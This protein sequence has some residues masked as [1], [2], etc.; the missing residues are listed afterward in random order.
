MPD[1]KFISILAAPFIAAVLIAVGAS[2]VV[3]F[4]T[5][6]PPKEAEIM[7]FSY[8]SVR[9]AR[10]QPIA[11]SSLYSPIEIPSPRQAAFPRVPL[12]QLA[13]QGQQKPEE[14]LSL[15]FIN[16]GKKMAVINGIVVKEG[17]VTGIGRVEKIERGRVLIDREQEK[18]WVKIE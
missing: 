6:L 10:R 15:I 1:K 16:K 12:S 18:I 9:I 11:V 3:K 2:A 7:K 17:D 8:S 14:K 4:R 5:E 13:P